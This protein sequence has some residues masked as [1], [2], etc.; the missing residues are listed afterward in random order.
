MPFLLPSS[1]DLD[2]GLSNVLITQLYFLWSL[3]VS[4]PWCL[5]SITFLPPKKSK[6]LFESSQSNKEPSLPLHLLKV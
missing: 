4:L 3:F 1:H 2:K 6:I 5:Y